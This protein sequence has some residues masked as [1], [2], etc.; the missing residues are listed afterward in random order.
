MRHPVGSAL[1]A[2]EAEPIDLAGAGRNQDGTAVGHQIAIDRQRIG[3]CDAGAFP[4]SH[5]P[6]YADEG[7]ALHARG[8][9]IGQ[10]PAKFRLIGESGDL[11]AQSFD[12]GEFRG[13]EL[14][15]IQDVEFG[16]HLHRTVI[17]LIDHAGNHHVADLAGDTRLGGDPRDLACL[18]ELLWQAAVGVG[19]DH[20]D[21]DR[22]ERH[23]HQP[24]RW[25][26]PARH[27]LD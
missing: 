19:R 7:D 14:P 21:R 10:P 5:G 2:F 24:Y 16:L 4:V 22:G 1:S 27:T 20:F 18:V 6:W 3:G 8:D 25:D 15:V 26:K 23:G 11:R 12:A 13:D 9:E 17:V